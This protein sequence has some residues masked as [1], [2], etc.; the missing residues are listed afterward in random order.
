MVG[1]LSRFS[2][3][4]ALIVAMVVAG[5][6]TRVVIGAAHTMTPTAE[7]RPVSVRDLLIEPDR[8]PA[9]YPGVMLEGTA[10]YRALQDIDGVVAGSVVTPPECAPLP[11]APQQTAAVQGVDSQNA[12]SLIV[13][14]T[15]PVAPL[16]ARAEQLTACPSFTA[17]HGEDVFTVTATT[18]PAPPV[19]A[20]DTY[21]VDQTATAQSTGLMS[22]T[23]TLAAQIGDIRV[24]ATWLHDGTADATPRHPRAGPLVHRRRAEGQTPRRALGHPQSRFHP[25]IASCGRCPAYRRRC[26]LPSWQL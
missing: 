20:D 17:A 21:A 8:F 15:R 3:A 25:Q 22:R 9:E 26:R 5:G 10:I 16:R 7:P 14:V 13:T 24:S 2:R 19:D 23:L 12:S 6:C 18:L 1:M 4:C 11:L